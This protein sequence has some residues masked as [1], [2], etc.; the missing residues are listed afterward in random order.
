MPEDKLDVVP[1]DDQLW[2]QYCDLAIRSYGHPIPDL[3]LLRPHAD[4]RVALR[5]GRVVA[6]GLG[7]LVPQHFGGRLVPAACM[8]GGCVAPEERGRH[9]TTHML[10]ERIRPLQDQGAVLATVWTTSTGYGHRLGWAAPAQTFTWTVPT[11]ELRRSFHATGYEIIHGAHPPSTQLQQNLAGRWN[12]PWRRPAWWEGWQQDK[13]PHYATY[14]FQLPGQNPSGQLS[15]A[16]GHDQTGGRQVVVH[17]FWASTGDTAAAMLAFLGRYNSRIPTVFFQRTGLPPTPVLLERL[18]RIG[19]ATA[20]HW[21]PWMIRILDLGAAIRQRG[22]PEHLDAAIAIEI[23]DD[24]TS[25]EPS[26]YTLRIQNGQ[27][28]LEPSSAPSRCTLTHRQI[29]VW[30]SGGYRTATAAALAG[31]DGDPCA[32]ADLVQATCDR[33]PWLPEHF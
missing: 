30:Y 16:F 20:R 32:I 12:G 7:L 31:L 8:A 5:G 15:V 2:S 6:G 13:H 33:E 17:D 18:H 14:R 27:A 11:E 29:A 4:A 23:T 21:H 19:S 1:A 9:L 25:S 24:T 3:A 10:T 22:W 28:D 26:R